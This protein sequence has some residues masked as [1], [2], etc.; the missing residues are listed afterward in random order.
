MEKRALQYEMS[1]E[2][3]LVKGPIIACI[4]ESDSMRYQD[5]YLW[6]KAVAL[7]LLITATQQ[8]RHW[9]VIGFDTG[10]RYECHVAPGM[11]SLETLLQVLA[12][13]P[14]GGTA[15]SPP[16][17]RAMEVLDSSTVMRQAD[18][19]FLTDGR[20]HVPAW[21]LERVLKAKADTG[22]HCYAI[23]IGSAARFDTLQTIPDERYHLSSD[24][25]AQSEAVAPLLAAIG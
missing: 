20:A 11:L 22:M 14:D 17:T 13:I 23:L 12:Y 9:R 2:Q 24:P 19:V 7:A 16:L 25:T 5:A 6:S 15:F 10:I 1:G 3:P 4:D 8:K 21:T 18:L